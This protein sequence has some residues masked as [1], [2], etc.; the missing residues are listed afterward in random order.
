MRCFRRTLRVNW[1]N[2]ITYI[3]ELEDVKVRRTL[4]KVI[5]KTKLAGHI[6]SHEELLR[7]IRPIECTTEVDNAPGQLRKQFI[8]K[9]GTG[10]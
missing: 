6:P 9:A 4:M 3:V 7:T 10:F 1:V 8:S 2:R 5:K